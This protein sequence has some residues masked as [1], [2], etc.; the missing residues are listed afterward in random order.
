MLPELSA[1]LL[2]G[3]AIVAALVLY[4]VFGGAGCGGGGWDVLASGPRKR[5]QRALIERAIGPIWE[6]N[7]VWLILVVVLVFTA[8]PR[9][10]SAISV[11]FHVPLS[12]FLI[13]I[14]FRGSS[15]A[16]RSFS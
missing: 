11:A 3:A 7:H 13:G 15:F 5:E 2:V 9:A 1:A 12:L 4:F 10:F 14:V 16:F 6:A 8:F